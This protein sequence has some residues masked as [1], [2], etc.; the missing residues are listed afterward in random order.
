MKASTRI[1]LKTN[2]QLRDFIWFENGKDGSIYFGNSRSNFKYGIKDTSIASKKYQFG[3]YIDPKNGTTLAKNELN[4]KYSFHNSGIIN[5]PTLNNNLSNRLRITHLEQYQEP[6]PL[7]NVIPMIPTKYP[8]S[9]KTIKKHDVIIDCGVNNGRC[10]GILFFT[11]K[12]DYEIPLISRLRENGYT[13][14]ITSFTLDKKN[15]GL[16]TYFNHDFL[17]WPKEQIEVIPH[18]DKDGKLPFPLITPNYK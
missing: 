7:L 18:P 5:L 12:E 1:F 16:M 10:L 17:G 11:I 13:I 14:D 9:N 3:T 15:I 4:N 6:T 8:E 2:D